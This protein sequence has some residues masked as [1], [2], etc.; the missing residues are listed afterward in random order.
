MGRGRTTTGT[1]IACL[2]MLRICHGRPIAIPSETDKTLGKILPADSGSSSSSED[3]AEE[4]VGEEHRKS[5]FGIDDIHFVKKIT[6]LFDRGVECREVLDWVIDRCSALQNIRQAVLQYRRVFN[7]QHVEPRVRRVALY[8]G[9]EYL[10][11]YFRLIAFAAYLGSEAFD[12]FCGQGEGKV[13]FKTWLHQRQEVQAMKWSIRLRPGRFFSLPVK[14]PGWMTP[15]PFLWETSNLASLCWTGA[16]RAAAAAGRCDYGGNREGEKRICAGQGLHPQELLLLR[17]RGP[18][19]LQGRHRECAVSWSGRGI[20]HS[21]HAHTQLYISCFLYD[22]VVQASGFPV[23]S[24][25]TPTASGLK[26]ILESLGASAQ[27]KVIVT[28]LRGEATVY[29]NGTPFVLRELDHPEDSLK[30]VGI[31]GPLVSPNSSLFFHEASFLSS[32]W[33]SRYSRPRWSTW[34][35]G[36]RRTWKRSWRREGGSC[37]CTGRRRT[38]F[39]A[40]VASSATGRKSPR[41]KWKRSPRFSLAWEKKA[42]TSTISA[43]PSPES[44][45]PSPPTLTPSNTAAHSTPL[46][47]YL[48]IYLSIDLYIYL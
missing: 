20:S 18:S 4:V 9:A 30:H 32:G 44:G 37:C 3:A 24:V 27:Q 19:H 10:E 46:S 26:E 29:I 36:S 6:R 38:R 48:C 47:I 8:R 21:Q 41:S 22:P 12:G 40:A 7:Q 31:T 11:R 5:R 13:S 1:V 15:P 2:L 34:R 43:F 35:G 17:R 14:C 42:T 45:I 23:F 25:A 28:D 39:P 33:Y 16:E